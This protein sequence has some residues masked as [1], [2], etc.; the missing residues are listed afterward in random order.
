MA[1]EQKQPKGKNWLL[2]ILLVLVL[3]VGGG[4]AGNYVASK[5]LAG[6][7]KTQKV[8]KKGGIAASKEIYPMNKFLVNLAT[9][10]SGS[11][12]YISIKISLVIPKSDA[13]QVKKNNALIRD[14][15]INV[16][17]QKR[18]SDILSGENAVPQLKQELKN[19]I[20]QNY[21][22]NIVSE[23]FITDMVIQ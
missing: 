15:V 13:S 23:V 5:Y 8:E 10:G 3:A 7:T 11:Q 20:N 17:R 1:E 21:G 2:I 12:K 14:S 4:V 22:K 9:D 6:S 16:L 18:E 19:T